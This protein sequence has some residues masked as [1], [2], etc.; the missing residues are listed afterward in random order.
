MPTVT[1]TV[2]RG[3]GGDG[4]A[5][6]R[7]ACGNGRDKEGAKYGM[8]IDAL[9]QVS[10]LTVFTATVVVVDSQNRRVLQWANGLINRRAKG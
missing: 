7:N 10:T 6:L 3:G 4:A 2:R 5:Y 1:L 8:I 9:R